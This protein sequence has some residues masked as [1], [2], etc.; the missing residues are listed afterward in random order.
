MSFFGGIGKALGMGGAGGASGG[1]SGLLGNL[2][3]HGPGQQG[4]QAMDPLTRMGMAGSMMNGD[5]GGLY[6]MWMKR[7]RQQEQD[8]PQPWNEQPPP[9]PPNP[10]PQQHGGGFFNMFGGMR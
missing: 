2:G 7:R 1:I 5:Y 6:D 8:H 9:G 10:F 4:G 3:I